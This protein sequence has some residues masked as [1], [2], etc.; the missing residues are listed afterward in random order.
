MI[1]RGHSLK[2]SRPVGQRQNSHPI[3]PSNQQ[4]DILDMPQC[5]K[6]DQIGRRQ[7][8]AN[9]PHTTGDS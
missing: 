9:P 3:H 4:L 5:E 2:P 7:S 6:R 8:S 1:Q